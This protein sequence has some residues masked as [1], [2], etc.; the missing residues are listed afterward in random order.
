MRHSR[1]SDIV[2]GKNFL[3]GGPLTFSSFTLVKTLPETTT[4]PVTSRVL[5]KKRPHFI[6]TDVV[7]ETPPSTNVTTED[8]LATLEGRHHEYGEKDSSHPDATSPAPMT[9]LPSTCYTKLAS[10]NTVYERSHLLYFLKFNF[11]YYFAPITF[12]GYSSMCYFLAKH[13]TSTAFLFIDNYL[14]YSQIATLL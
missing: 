9:S 13:Y 5:D 12:I 3:A 1:S 11:I 7:A 10:S 8:I 14:V 6:K 4:A 2:I